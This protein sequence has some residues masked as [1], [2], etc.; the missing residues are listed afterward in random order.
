[1]TPR[2]Q[3]RQEPPHGLIRRPP[4][5]EAFNR[6][7]GQQVDVAAHAFGHIGEF[8]SVSFRIIDPA[9]QDIL[10]S[11]LAPGAIEVVVGGLNK[12]L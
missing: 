6:V 2:A 3:P 9:E 1:M 4:V 7:E 11:H 5:G 8:T 12:R 10:E